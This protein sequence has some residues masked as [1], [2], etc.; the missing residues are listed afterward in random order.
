MNTSVYSEYFHDDDR[1]MEFARALFNASDAK[2][3]QTS[4][5]TTRMYSKSVGVIVE[6]NKVILIDGH[7]YYVWHS[8]NQK[9]L[10]EEYEKKKHELIEN[11][12]MIQFLHMAAAKRVKK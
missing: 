9:V 6:G 2:I 12:P 10:R 7:T 4:I 3:E 11:I 8:K 5:G 1:A